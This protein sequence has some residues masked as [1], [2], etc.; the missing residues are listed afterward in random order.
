M[1]KVSVVY[2]LF[3]GISKREKFRMLLELWLFCAEILWL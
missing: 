2:F 3:I 1:S